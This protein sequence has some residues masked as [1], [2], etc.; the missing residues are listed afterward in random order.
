M[1][2]VVIFVLSV[3]SAAMVQ[4]QTRHALVVGIDTY[5]NVPRLAKAV[6]DARGVSA[7]LAQLGFRVDTLID[8]DRRRLG[9]G[10]SALASAIQPGDEV[11]FFF[12][13]HGIEV[14]G[15]N[16][17][18]P[19]DVPAARPGDEDFVTGESIAVDRIVSAI[20]SRGARV[21]LLILDACRDNPF[22]VQGTRSLGGSRGLARVD[23]PEGVFIL[24]SAGTGQTAL[25]RLSASDADPNS[26]FTRALL[27]RLSQPGMTIHDMVQSVRSDVRSLARS[28][29]HDQFPAY[30]DQISG[31]FMLNPSGMR[32]AVPLGTPTPTVAPPPAPDPCEA[33]RRDWQV[34][35]DTQS[36]NALAAFVQTHANC[37]LFATLAQER[38]ASLGV[39]SPEPA[40]PQP[41][42]LCEALWYQRNLIFHTKGFCFT[43]A[44]AKAAFD[45]SRCT[46]SSPVLSAAEKAEV[47]RIQA[48][49][50]ANGC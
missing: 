23:P 8:P 10:I 33:A 31:V 14:A 5:D 25:D 20:Q 32:G 43:S 42:N 47:A 16:Y 19:S 38:A 28:V 13:G 1:R 37:P 26:V 4:A 22:P 15:R 17:L 49:E 6:N 36:A 48:Q 46:T 40:M 30:Y 35:Q 11:V 18:L 2:W 7:A 34:L 12:A 45:T 27:P 41:A 24:F 44:R 3:L 39:R 29:S 50:K 9:Q 21:A